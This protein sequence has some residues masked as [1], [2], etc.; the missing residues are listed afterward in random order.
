MLNA[1]IFIFTIMLAIVSL[2]IIF[3]KDKFSKFLFLNIATNICVLIII[4]MSSYQYNSS[5]LDIALIYVLLSYIATQ[6]LL[7][8]I[9]EK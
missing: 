1:V 4:A 8:F 9:L 3:I 7:K 5:F 6:G 2:S